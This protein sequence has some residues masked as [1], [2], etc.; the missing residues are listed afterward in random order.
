MKKWLIRIAV[1]AVIA[2]VAI[3][4]VPR[5]VNGNHEGKVINAKVRYFDGESEMIELKG[6]SFVGGFVRLDTAYGDVIYVG[7]NNAII[8]KEEKRDE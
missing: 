5:W 4:I 3:F 7:A 1:L 8:T 2:C 6:Y